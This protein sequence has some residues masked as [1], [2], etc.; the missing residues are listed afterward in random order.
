MKQVDFFDLGTM[1]FAEC[2]Q[3][4]EKYF[5]ELS[6]NKI[7][8]RNGQLHS[9]EMPKGKLLFVEHP[10]V[11]TLGKSG[12]VRN[13]LLNNASLE[14][15]K[16]EFF[17]INRGGDITYHGPGQLVGYPIIDLENYFTDIH[18][19]LR[20]L[21]EAIILMLQSFGIEGGR[22]NGLTGV[23]ID[24]E[25]PSKARKIAAMGVKCSRWI[26]MHGFALN[27]N[28]D[29]GYFQHIVPCGITDKAVT[30]MEAELGKK[31][32]FDEV[33][34]LLKQRLADTFGFEW[35]SNP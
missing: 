18:K 2:W 25:N 20:L 6:D 29:L 30:S 33:K 32:V 16:A 27:V 28:P 13:L 34:N 5:T 1:S 12:D 23:W 21:E 10:H 19:Y 31:V 3:L 14:A 26:T 35:T 8:R 7:A 17:P 24:A 22:I 9:G 15:V 11:F 4:Q